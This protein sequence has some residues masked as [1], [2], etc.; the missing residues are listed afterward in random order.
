VVA[1]FLHYVKTLPVLPQAY[2]FPGST[3]LRRANHLRSSE[4]FLFLN[5]RCEH[6]LFFPLLPLSVGFTKALYRV[7]FSK[8]LHSV[9][10]NAR[11]LVSTFIL[12][13]ALVSYNAWCFKNLCLLTCDAIQSHMS[14]LFVTRRDFYTRSYTICNVR[15]TALAPIGRCDGSSATFRQP[16]VPPPFSVNS[17]KEPSIG[18]DG[19]GRRG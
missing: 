3:I 11:A 16:S 8:A 5:A 6:F 7:E 17:P 1:I 15:G 12:V 2:L 13:R 18:G 4:H 19:S 14:L 9:S 10:F